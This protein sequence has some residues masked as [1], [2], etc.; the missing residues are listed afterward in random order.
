LAEALNLR[1]DPSFVAIVPLGGRHVNHLWRLLA[2][3]QIPY[4][5]L[6]DL[7]LG[8]NGG[9][10]G[11]VKTTCRELLNVGHTPSQVFGTG[12]TEA[13]VEVRLGA[14]DSW[15]VN[16][17]TSLRGW[18][19]HLQTL[20]IHFCI[21]LDLDHSLLHAYPA[22]YREL[23]ASLQGP[24]DSDPRAA[25]LGARGQHHLYSSDDDLDVLRWYRYLFLG[26]GKPSTHVRVLSVMDAAK[27][28]ASMP[29]PLQMLLQ[30]VAAA[31]N[32]GAVD[33]RG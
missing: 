15:D 28:R 3:L 9:G 30:Q 14:F 10:W 8:R 33:A 18:L 21:P 12:A 27:L 13:D 24:D 4:A 19:T 1:I 2:E 23:P 11:R 32:P 31:I 29:E 26:R 7:D 6:L 25:V 17:L 5:T 16:D 20:R 22:A